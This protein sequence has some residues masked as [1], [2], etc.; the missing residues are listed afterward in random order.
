MVRPR[1]RLRSGFAMTSPP[2]EPV[3]WIADSIELT[4]AEA[5]RLLGAMD[6]AV[7]VLPP[8]PVRDELQG[9]KRLVIS[10]LTPWLGEILDTGLEE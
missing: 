8:G 10:K 1:R 9:A 2:D 7:D 6:D 4:R 3:G 5:G